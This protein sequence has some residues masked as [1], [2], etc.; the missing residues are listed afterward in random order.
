MEC[1]MT[2]RNIFYVDR[3]FGPSCHFQCPQFL[4]AA[5]NSNARREISRRRNRVIDEKLLERGNYGREANPA[6]FC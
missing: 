5:I 2:L 4:I 6:T 3:P 1:S